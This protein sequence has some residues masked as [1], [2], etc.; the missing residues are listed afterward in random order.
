MR[1]GVRDESNR[2]CVL[3]GDVSGGGCDRSVYRSGACGMTPRVASRLP[4]DQSSITT[5]ATSDKEYPA[6]ILYQ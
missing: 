3:C 4:G 5:V 2:G 6:P 1:E